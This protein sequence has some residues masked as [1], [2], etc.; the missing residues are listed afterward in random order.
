MLSFTKNS[1]YLIAFVFSLLTCSPVVAFL[2]SSDS[3]T[4]PADPPEI[5]KIL[6]QVS[7]NPVPWLPSPVKDNDYRWQAYKY[8]SSGSLALT[9]GRPVEFVDDISNDEMLTDEALSFVRC[10]GVDLGMD[11]CAERIMSQRNVRGMRVLYIRPEIDGV[12]VYGGYTVLSVN[13]IGALASVKARGFGDVV[14]GSFSLNEVEAVSA[15]RN[16][17]DTFAGSSVVRR[18]Y[19]PVGDHGNEIKLR[20]CYEVILTPPDP[21]FRPVLFVDAATGEIRAAENRIWYDRLEGEVQ[22][23]YKPHYGPD[24][25]VRSPFMNE[26]MRLSGGLEFFTDENG[27]F[28]CD[29]NPGNLPMNL[30]SELR[31]R[32]VD[33]NYEDGNDGRLTAVINGMERL[34][35]TWTGNHAR[36]DER[37]LYYHVNFIHDFWKQLDPE[38]D[39]LDYPMPAVCGYGNHFDNAFWNG[40][41]IYFGEGN[42]M[43]N[44]ALYADIIYHE[45]GHGVTSNIYPYHVLPYEGESGALNE[46]WSDYFPCSITDEPLM[47]E[48]GLRGGGYIRNLDNNL[49]YP[50]DLRGEVHLD[51]RIISAAMWHTREVLG[52]EI[53]DPLFHFARY[54]LG[55]DFISY[56][57]D[58]LLTDDNDGDITNGTPHDHVLYEQFCRHGIGPGI[59]PKISIV[60]LQMIDDRN[61]GA[62]GNDNRVWE[63]GETIRIEIEL[64]RDGILY[65]PAAE[66]V[67][68]GLS[69]EHE[70]VVPVRGEIHFGNMSVGDRLESFEPLLFRIDDDA[71]LSFADIVLTIVSDEDHLIDRDTVRIPL[72]RP[73]L[74]LVK[75][76]DEGKDRS[77]YITSS[78]DSLGL[79]YVSFSTAEPI[80][81]LNNRLQDIRTVIWF[82]GDAQH[83]IL[84]EDDRSDLAVFLEGGGNLLLTGQSLGAVPGA[85]QFFNEYLGARNV[86]DSL[87]RWWLD[88]VEDDPVS[89]GL[90]L[91]LLGD[92]GARNQYRPGTIEAIAPAVEIYHW[93][94]EEGEPAGGVRREDPETGAR[95]V[96]FSFGLEG[97][98]GHGYTST[99]TTV[100]RYALNWLG[101]ETDVGGESVGVPGEFL[102]GSPYP[103]PFN[104]IL[105]VPFRLGK[106]GEVSLSVY[107]LTGRKIWTGT[108]M[109]G[110]GSRIWTI[111]GGS[112][113]SGIYIIRGLSWEGTGAV[114]VVLLK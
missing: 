105:M 101:I 81:P 88:G 55:N 63:Q 44:F 1:A 79:T 75:D 8:Q 20:A 14:S 76:G 22:G 9:V 104:H 30:H 23:W 68:V 113:G 52:R 16:S 90:Q 54:E 19:L 95:T 40:H 94:R 109:F 59:D 36:D 85:E 112:W 42:E 25:S 10:H 100:A 70:D 28:E 102:L 65:P 87:R 3:R 24:E 39:A 5:L 83:T 73:E 31:G 108:E 56:F 6:G 91:L 71:P 35:I 57:T 84:S 43:D 92:G 61:R 13:S 50:R 103:N 51:S 11:N 27:E 29:I 34:V 97:V 48:G 60:S 69:C 41:G 38:F 78:L 26:W 18:V 67:R 2:A 89:Q 7:I 37:T 99:R 45:Y 111:S 93:T 15:A 106:P 32:Y 82:S 49:V 114:R 80:V 86:I 74:L 4:L 58:V 98:G 21:G 107:D 47:G 12:P 77:P 72:C 46:A 17:I 96:Y 53:T 33:V 110:T 62:D 64:Y 66:D